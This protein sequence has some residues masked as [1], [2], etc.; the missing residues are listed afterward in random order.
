MTTNKLSYI[1]VYT[2]IELVDKWQPSGK[3]SGF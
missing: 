2:Y 3:K 1:L